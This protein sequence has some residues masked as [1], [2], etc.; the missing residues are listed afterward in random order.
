MGLKVADEA[1]PAKIHDSREQNIANDPWR[2]VVLEVKGCW[3][4][5]GSSV[6]RGIVSD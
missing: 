3:A 6:A 4:K 5:I 2:R 1:L